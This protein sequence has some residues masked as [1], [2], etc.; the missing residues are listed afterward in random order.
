[1]LQRDNLNAVQELKELIVSNSM[2]PNKKQCYTNF[3]ALENSINMTKAD[4]ASN[5]TIPLQ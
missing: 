1:M 5:V 4:P 3:L 2:R